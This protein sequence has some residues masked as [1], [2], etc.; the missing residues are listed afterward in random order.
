M[1]TI[2]STTMTPINGGTVYEIIAN[3]AI[4]SVT[5]LVHDSTVI[6]INVSRMS[7]S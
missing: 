2:A 6:G 3:A 5:V 1:Y 4:Q 7:M